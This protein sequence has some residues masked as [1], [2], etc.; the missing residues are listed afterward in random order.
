MADTSGQADIRN[1]KIDD[2][3]KGFQDEEFV[4]R[5]FISVVSTSA[6]EIRW[7]Q[8]TAGVIDTPDTTAIT[9]SQIAN[10]S[11]LTKPYVV[12]QSWTRNTSYIRKFMAETEWISEEDIKDNMVQ[13]WA[14][15]IRDTTRAVIK[16]VNDHIYNV[17]TENQSP[18]NILTTASTAAWDTASYSGVDIIKDINT[19]IR[20]IRQ[21]NY[22]PTHL[23]LSPKDFDSMISWLIS[24]KGSS[25]PAFASNKLETGV[26]M[27]ILGLRVVVSNSVAADSA[28][29]AAPQRAVT[30][31]EFMSISTAE[32]IEPL[33]G[34][35][36][37]VASEVIALLTDPS[38]VH[39]TT[40]T[41]A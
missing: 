1:I 5:N 35:K 37:R 10:V 12:S 7:V 20:K 11:H 9:A 23:F 14:T 36:Y 8:K 27:E 17:L 4:F 34:R 28:C 41:Q 26:V 25:I 38:A 13:L 24:S 39:L 16:Q 30:M 33:I 18:V 31:H 3:V 21:N 19:G 22:E 29:I 2:L 40:N 6:R 32:I 15:T